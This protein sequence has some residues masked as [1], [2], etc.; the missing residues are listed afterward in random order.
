MRFAIRGWCLA[1]LLLPVSGILAQQAPEQPLSLVDRVGTTGF[2][3]LDAESFKGLSLDQKLDAY[4][5]SRAAIAV[6]PIVYD[7]NS[8]YGLREK[9]LLEQILTHSNRIDPAVLKEIVAYTKL[10]LGN[11]GNHQTFTSQKFLPEFT[12]E[13]L[14]VA[15]RRALKNGAHLG[16]GQQLQRE[17]RVLQRPL[18]DPNFKPMRTMKNPPDGGDP[19]LESGNNLYLGVTRADLTGFTERFALN[20]RLVKKNGK[21]VEEVYR[22]GTPDGRIPPGLY[23]KE[24]SQAI[25]F[26]KKALPYSTDSQKKVINDLIRY[27]QTGARA[28]WIQCGIDW[29]HDPTNP[30][31]SNGFVEVYKDVRGAKGAIQGFVTVVDQPMNRLM[32]GFAENA[33]Y[34][35]QRAPWDAKYKQENP[36]PPLVNAVEALIETGDFGVTTIGDNLPNEAEIHAK[37][38]SKSF[39][40]TGSMR[41]LNSATGIK[42]AEEFSNS[43]AEI[44]RARKYGDLAEDLFTAMHEVIG[45]GS[46]RLDP[47][48]THEP[49]YYIKEYYSTLEE[50]RADLMALWNFWDPK[51]V[52]MG[53]MPSYDVAKAAYDG[54]ARAALIQLRE[55]PTGDTIEEDHRRGT[56]LIVNYIRDKTGAIQP[57]TRGGKIYMVVT[58]YQGMRKGVGMLLAELMRI[59]A[60]GDY[61]G[62]KALITQYGIHFN[63]E[64]RDQVV[65]RYKTLNLPTYWAGINPELELHKAAD[66]TVDDVEI[67]YPRDLLKQQLHY[68][69]INGE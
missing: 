68:S 12:S 6:D 52:Q 35:E 58:D 63:P 11:R 46:G 17:L 8:I 5:L 9:R 33:A 42:V 67:L 51:L 24:L 57:M 50:T 27:Y 39:I 34:F 69:E 23:A 61:D 41:A 32:K 54:E 4:W 15:A 10:F 40:F 44:E 2:I 55:V 43:Q 26:L 14:G 28:D 45:H 38:G 66:G 49:A 53:A 59:K 16:T 64:W 60:E 7:Q 31:F 29:V 30:D 62:A 3:Q 36:R 47:K 19:L 37:Y 22:A 18:F 1:L 48:L 65:A 20:S 25:R 56:Q 13:E 21:L